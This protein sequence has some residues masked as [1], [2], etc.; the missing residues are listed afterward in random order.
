MTVVLRK[1]A[2]MIQLSYN[3]T[4]VSKIYDNLLS[5][6]VKISSRV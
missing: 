5:K 6:L 2:F 1:K 3:Y 4:E